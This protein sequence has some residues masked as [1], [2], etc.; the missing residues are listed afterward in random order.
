LLAE[1]A[2]LAVGAL[3]DG[4]GTPGSVGGD[5]D[6][7]DDRLVAAPVGGL[8]AGVGAEPLMAVVG[9]LGGADRAC[10]HRRGF[11][12]RRGFGLLV[13]SGWRPGFWRRR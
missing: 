13:S 6:G 9:E 12:A 2:G 11:V 3:V 1:V 7:L 10:P 5:L 4:V 8:A